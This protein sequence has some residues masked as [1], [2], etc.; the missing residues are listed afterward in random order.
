MKKF[1]ASAATL[2]AL[3]TPAFATDEECEV[4]L[5]QYNKLDN[6]H[7][8]LGGRRGPRLRWHPGLFFQIRGLQIREGYS[9]E[10][11]Y[12]SFSNGTM[13]SKQHHGL[14]PAGVPSLSKSLSSSTSSS[15]TRPA[16]SPSSRLRR[17]MRPKWAKRPSTLCRSEED[18]TGSRAV[19]PLKRCLMRPS[20]IPGRLS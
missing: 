20:V 8:L 10:G 9:W 15:T 13:S 4:N 16:R 17:P 7:A 3:A 18:R 12:L 19:A 2:L 14:R 1:L 6:R 11:M 5:D